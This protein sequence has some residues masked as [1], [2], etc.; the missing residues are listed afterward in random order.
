MRL[1]RVGEVLGSWRLD[2]HIGAGGM[3]DVYL[4]SRVDGVVQMKA[5]VK[6]LEGPAGA[7]STVEADVVQR[8]NHSN[9]ARYL[10]EGVTSDGHNYIVMEFVEGLPITEYADQKGMSIFERL[11]LF[12]QVC[13]AVDYAHAHLVLHLD[14]K[15]DNILVDRLGVVKIIDFGVARTISHD[16]RTEPALAFSAPYASPEQIEGRRLGFATDIYALGAVLYELISGRPPFNP[17]DPAELERQILEELPPLPSDSIRHPRVKYVDGRMNRLEPESIARMRGGL[18]LAEVQ[19]VLGGNLD[20]ICL[21]ALRKGEGRR[22]R[23]ASDLRSDLESVLKGKR[24]GIARSGDRLFILQQAVRRR[25]IEIVAAASILTGSV[26]A[27]VTQSF[28]TTGAEIA[29][30]EQNAAEE[31]ARHTQDAIRDQLRPQLTSDSRMVGAL[32]TVDT[33]LQ[34]SE[35]AP[36]L[37]DAIHAIRRRLAKNQ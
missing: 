11:H 33:V 2:R 29:R 17:R 30:K 37:G 18:S 21:H 28:L 8:L 13:D 31:V 24:P 35:P 10:G 1:D 14:L 19:K 6:V 34:A 32:S 9:V 36:T 27:L 26:G 3:G 23:W 15:P 25:T 4:A 5:A 12:M 7:D 20:R 22:Y 16:H